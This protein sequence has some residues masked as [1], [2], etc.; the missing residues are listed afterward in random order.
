[1]NE[2]K[3]MQQMGAVLSAFMVLFYLGIGIFLIFIFDASLSTL[4]RPVLVI[5][6]AVCLFYGVYR[7]Y[8]SYIKI[9]DLFFKPDNEE[10]E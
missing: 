3:M 4:G 2:N 1:M 6:G 9:R 8:T 7:A 10:D 5:F